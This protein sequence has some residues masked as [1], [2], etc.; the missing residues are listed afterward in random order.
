[1]QKKLWINED[2][3]SFYDYRRQDEMSVE[4]LNSLVDTYAEN[5][6][7]KGVLFC[8][9]VQ[10]ALFDSKA[11]EP[12][13]AGYDP[14]GPDDQPMFRFLSP[15]ARSLTPGKRGRWWVHNL[16]LLAE[17]GIDHPQVWL[18]R[19]RHHGLQGWLSM[20]MNDCH[21]NPDPEAFWHSSFWRERPD[22]H[23]AAHRDEGWFETAFDYGK[24]EVVE[25]HMS[26]LRE[27]CG[28]YD[29]DG[30]ELDWMR[31][32]KHFSPG[33]EVAGRAILN[34][35]MREARRLTDA[36][37][38]RLGHPVRLGVRLPTQ[39]QAAWAWGYDVPTWGR[40][41][42]VDLVTLAPFL[43]QSL[44]EFEIDLW[45]AVLGEGV[46]LLAQT[47]AGMHAWP[48]GGKGAK[49]MD[50]NFIFGGAAAALREGADG[51]Y[52]FNECYRVNR[53]DGITQRN[54]GLLRDLLENA[55]NADMLLEHPRRH[56]VSYHQT[57]GPGMAI[58]C[59]LPVPL[60]QPE[61]TFDIGRY[62]ETMPFRIP[63]GPVPEQSPVWLHVGVDV[64]AAPVAAEGFTVWVNGQ[65][66]GQG[67]DE[68]AEPPRMPT[69]VSRCLSWPVDREMLL[70]GINQ[71][72]VRP[73]AGPG[74]IVWVELQVRR[75]MDKNSTTDT[76]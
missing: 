55:G 12:L 75:K 41:K 7:V 35:F 39:L 54:P 69:C 62:R 71:I 49:I 63:L 43:S 21:H 8:V 61:G 31:W 2:N 26:L 29:M 56:P 74:N 50:Y 48:D 45:R 3:A 42:L 11:W 67:P 9:N 1:M 22:L 64:A 59:V 19:C 13:Y 24:P 60:T 51:V 44:F 16:W 23:R 32:I 18:D 66:I 52:L 47:D 10:R 53:D 34:D 6:S 73:P 15:E 40:E 65:P 68:G 25:Y 57:P 5:S 37:A 20:R 27:L 36:A 38:Q 76:K 17:R 4:G 30:I 70:D 28:R 72:E 58:P 46:E 14:E 33:G